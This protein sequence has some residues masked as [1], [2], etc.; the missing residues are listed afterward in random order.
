MRR[1]VSDEWVGWV[2]L[3]AQGVKETQLLKGGGWGCGGWGK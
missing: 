3:S 1:A 2:G